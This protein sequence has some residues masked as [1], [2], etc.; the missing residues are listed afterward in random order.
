MSP[1]KSSLGRGIPTIGGRG[2]GVAYSEGLLSSRVQEFVSVT[3]IGGPSIPG[4]LSRYAVFYQ[5]RSR[6]GG[7]SRT[8][9]RILLFVLG[10]ILS[11]R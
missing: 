4:N 1:F 10:N 11:H 9:L 7:L 6:H 5:R 3:T 8:D 2:V